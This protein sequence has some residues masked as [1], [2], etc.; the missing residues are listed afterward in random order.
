MPY[1]Q[2][3]SWH[4]RPFNLVLR[5]FGQP[6]SI[7]PGVRRTVAELDKNLP[8]SD[9]RTMDKV[10]DETYSLKNFVTMLLA[11]FG[12]LALSLAAVGIYGLMAYSVAQR[13]QEIGV[14]MALGAGKRDILRSVIGQGLAIAFAGSVVGL[15]AAFALT[16]LLSSQLYG[17][18]ATDP[19]TFAVTP[20]LLWAVA[21]FATYIPA[22]RAARVDPLTALRYE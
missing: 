9:V 1:A 5:T 3:S 12:G 10:A 7:V 16:R 20:V 11:S 17:V 4:E 8:I 2:Y 19:V 6:L 18:T 22:R 21:F 14:R 15:A 13:T